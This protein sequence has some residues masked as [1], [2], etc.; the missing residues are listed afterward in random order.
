MGITSPWWAEPWKAN[1]ARR[2]LLV[3]MLLTWKAKRPA[4]RTR[5]W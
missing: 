4:E 2:R 5:V 1:A 3:M